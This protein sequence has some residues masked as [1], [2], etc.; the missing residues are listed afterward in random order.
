MFTFHYSGKKIETCFNLPQKNSFFH[1]F[2]R[3]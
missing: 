2:K 1:N 3:Y